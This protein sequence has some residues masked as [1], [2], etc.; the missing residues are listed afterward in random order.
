MQIMQASQENPLIKIIKHDTDVN[1]IIENDVDVDNCIVN[2]PSGKCT[3]FSIG[4][5]MI[6]AIILAILGALHYL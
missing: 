3:W 1:V 4:I 5:V 2:C 6:L